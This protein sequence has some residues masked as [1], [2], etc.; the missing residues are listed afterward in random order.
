MREVKLPSGATLKVNPS[1]FGTSKALYQAVLKEFRSVAFSSK[2][3]MAELFKSLFCIGFSSPEIEAC[4]WECFKRC[5]YNGGAGD[6]KIDQDTFE[7]VERRDDYMVVCSEVAKDNIGPFV[8]SLFAGYKT[9]MAMTE[10]IQ[11]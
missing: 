6:L 4:L 11:L 5:T 1:P 2:T 3:D 7:A 9:F 10:S 8:K